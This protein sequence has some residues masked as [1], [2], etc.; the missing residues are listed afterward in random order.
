MRI[1]ET[2]RILV[3]DDELIMRESLSD[4]LR[5]DGYGVEAVDNGY[6]ALEKVKKERWDI[7]LVDLKMPGIDGIEVMQRV[8]KI[9]KGLPVVII[10]AY[11]TVDTA[12]KA[13]KE[14]AYDYI[15]KPFNPEE[16]GLIIR[17]IIAHQNLIKENIYLRQELKKRYEFKDI[18]GKSHKMQDVLE[19][20]KTVAKSNTTVLIEGES[21]TGKELVAR[22]IHSL[23]LRNK[24]PFVAVSCAALPETL[25]E[26]ELF[27]Y[28]KGAF[29]GAV[30]TRIGNFELADN[31][32]LFLDEVGDTSLKTQADLLRVLE[33]KEFRRV[34]GTKLIEVDVRIISATNR[35]LKK[36][37]NEDKFREDLYYRLNVVSIHVPPLRERKEDIPLFAEHFLKK[38]SIENKKDVEWIEEDALSL[39]MKYDWPGNVRELENVIERAV[40]LVKRNFIGVDELP[41]FVK[42]AEKEEFKPSLNRPLKEIERE[43]IFW[44][45]KANQWK[46]KKV[47][48]IL[49][50]DRTTLYNKVKKY[51][52]KQN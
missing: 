47:A 14:G 10:T 49:G 35:N 7:L 51:N 29:T 3:V 18:I 50:I 31:G 11:A 25:L 4:W 41:T 26:S 42:I 16:I 30:A 24:E 23:S 39:L 21:G 12:V 22:A 17:N 20:I 44:V 34:G 19:M 5:E 6:K 27:G 15:V 33:E 36:L 28:E 9:N 13:I 1:R 48:T 45:L 37:I 38:Y 40:V 52:L 46:I 2:T 32:T 43:Y 8:K